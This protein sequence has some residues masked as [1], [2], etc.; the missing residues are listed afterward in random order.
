M[1]N[2]YNENEKND[3]LYVL[4]TN[5]YPM[6]VRTIAEKAGYTPNKTFAILRGLVNEFKVE[7][8][9]GEGTKDAPTYILNYS[10]QFEQPVDQTKRNTIDDRTQLRSNKVGEN[11]KKDILYVLQTNDY[12]MTAKTIA[13]K[14][15]YTIARTVAILRQLD[16]I[17]KRPGEG[18]KDAPTYFLSDSYQFEQPLSQNKRFMDNPNTIINN[19]SKVNN[20]NSFGNNLKAFGVGINGGYITLDQDL[21]VSI[22]Y[23][24]YCYYD[25]QTEQFIY[26]I[27]EK[28]PITYKEGYFDYD[29][30]GFD[31]DEVKYYG[32]YKI[33]TTADLYSMADIDIDYFLREALRGVISDYGNNDMFVGADY[34]VVRNDSI[35]KSGYIYT[36]FN[37]GI[38]YEI[39]PYVMYIFTNK[40][41]YSVEGNFTS[42]DYIKNEGL[43]EQFLNSL[44]IQD[45]K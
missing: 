40:H 13:E 44:N 24:D 6:T 23:G 25:S 16:G 35:I 10:Y 32:K 39:R 42:H 15:G 2:F 5:D 20:E 19:F 14:A 17:E 31:D 30:N 4:Q 11:E 21:V 8:R 1:N 37:F 27:P 12:P 43:V 41:W 34:K 38:G 3:I 33:S 9:P 22:T 36:R 18:I 28:R 29:S 45:D 7:K 26:I